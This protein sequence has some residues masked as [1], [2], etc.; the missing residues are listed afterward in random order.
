MNAVL[1]ARGWFATCASPPG[2]IAVRK[3]W[4]IVRIVVVAANVLGEKNDVTW[5]CAAEIDCVGTVGNKRQ[6]GYER[7]TRCDYWNRLHQPDGK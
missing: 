5:A 1:D 3:S 4:S 6:H 2:R 7:K